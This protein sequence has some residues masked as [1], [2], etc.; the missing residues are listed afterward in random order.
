[1]LQA[2]HMTEAFVFVNCFLAMT[3]TVESM[4][5]ITEGV[6]GA[7]VTSGIYDIVLK[8]KAPDDRLRDVIQRVKRIPGVAA[9]MTSIVTK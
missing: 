3:N 4:A 8:I 9:I 7:Y 1:M 2:S 6:S 5:K